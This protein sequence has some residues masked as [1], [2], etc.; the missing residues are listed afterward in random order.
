V[1][2]Q[3][4]RNPL[5]G[6]LSSVIRRAAVSNE[7]DPVSTAAFRSRD[8]LRVA[9]LV[10][11]L[12]VLGWVLLHRFTG[13]GRFAEYQQTVQQFFVAAHAKDSLRLRAMA[14]TEQPVQWALEAAA[15]QPWL[16]PPVDS[17]FEIRRTRRAELL[18]GIVVWPAG[19]CAT[20]PYFMTIATGDRG[21][22]IHGIHTS[23]GSASSEA[24]P[25]PR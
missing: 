17:G 16:L 2:P 6:A 1:R 21:P 23:C 22:R 19:P 4:N 5:C 8:W 18:D 13:P 3:L 12:A 20:Q 15:G 10:V 24:A 14:D 9:F 11:V 7:V 25:I